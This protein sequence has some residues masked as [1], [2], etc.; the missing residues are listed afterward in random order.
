MTAAEIK[1]A[2]KR[3][4]GFRDWFKRTVPKRAVDL[5]VVLYPSGSGITV[6]GKS[7]ETLIAC[8][9]VGCVLGWAGAYPPMKRVLSKGI[10]EHDYLG[11]QFTE[12][13]SIFDSCHP[14]E[15]ADQ[16]AAAIARLN[17]HIKGLR[18]VLKDVA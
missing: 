2:I 8:G 15:G 9:T 11:V 10:T 16:K 4:Q 3:T 5:D 14:T 1:Q 6:A 12:D 13:D 17:K 18:E 7:A